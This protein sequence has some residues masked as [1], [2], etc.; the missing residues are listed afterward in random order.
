MDDQ[1]PKSDP[2]VEDVLKQVPRDVARTLTPRQW[3]GFREGLRRSLDP[4]RHLIDLR[5]TIPLYF[6]RY[7]FVIIVGRDPRGRVQRFLQERRRRASKVMAWLLVMLIIWA[8]VMLG[9]LIAL[10]FSSALH[11]QFLPEGGSE[12]W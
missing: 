6:V 4:M 1:E 8:L 3:D 10:L 11:V 5:F 2:F 7:F 12:G 9:L